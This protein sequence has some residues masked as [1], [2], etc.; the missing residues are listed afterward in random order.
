M[1][2][3]R[4][5]A[6][7]IRKETGVSCVECMDTGKRETSYYNADGICACAAGDGLR[8]AKRSREI[9]GWMAGIGSGIGIPRRYS[10]CTVE[11]FPDRSS[12]VLLS[13]TE[14]VSNT[15][16]PPDDWITGRGLYLSGMFGR[17]KTG[18][19]VA[20]LRELVTR[21]GTRDEFR[22]PPDYYAQFVTSTAM[23]EG[24]R[25][26]ENDDHAPTRNLR[27][28]R[29]VPVLAID[30]FGAERVTE[31][32]VDRLFEIINHRHN[33][34]L[35]TLIT[36]NLAPDELAA[37]INR[38]VGGQYGDRIVERIVESCDIVTFPENARNWRME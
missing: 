19:A 20:G 33:E 9:N 11:T 12:P 6:E 26:D 38:Q 24:L 16:N 35:P 8:A 29:T 3:A 15:A 25:P 17:G 2:E 4:T 14:W 23:L 21:V 28:L 10:D 13:L 22:R 1:A 31:W 36:S 18:L 32:G 37:K 7:R 27:R 5:E 30:D 34:L